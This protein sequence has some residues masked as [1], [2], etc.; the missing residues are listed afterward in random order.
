MPLQPSKMINSFFHKHGAYKEGASF[1]F[2]V[3]VINH[4]LGSVTA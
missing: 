2:E 1:R 4:P 3:R